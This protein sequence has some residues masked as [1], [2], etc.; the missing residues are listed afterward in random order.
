VV[1]LVMLLMHLQVLVSGWL[2]MLV[3]VGT[4]PQP[5]VLVMPLLLLHGVMVMLSHVLVLIGGGIV[6]SNTL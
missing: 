5:V 4:E 2:L 6:V 3:L 1:L